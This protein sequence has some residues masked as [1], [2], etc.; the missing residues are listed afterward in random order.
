M[1]RAFWSGWD[2]YYS[3]PFAVTAWQFS[4]Y[5][6]SSLALCCPLLISHTILTSTR[7]PSPLFFCWPFFGLMRQRYWNLLVSSRLLRCWPELHWHNPAH[8]H[9]AA[10]FA[11]LCLFLKLPEIHVNSSHRNELDGGF[12]PIWK[13]CSSNWIIFPGR[14]EHSKNVWNHHLVKRLKVPAAMKC[15]QQRSS[16]TNPN[17]ALLSREILQN[18]H[19]FAFKFDPR[20]MGPISWPLSKFSKLVFKILRSSRSPGSFL[21]PACPD[22]PQLSYHWKLVCHLHSNV[23][24][25][26]V[27]GHIIFKNMNFN[28]ENTS[29][30]RYYSL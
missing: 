25:S 2:P 7:P 9:G 15:I 27:F 26:N 13:I 17:N 18:Y 19:M 29:S 5:T 24:F 20:K 6:S 14:D 8:Q 22:T 11:S 10:S 1:F 23:I 12:Q 30:S 3:P 4:R 21:F 16:I 28:L